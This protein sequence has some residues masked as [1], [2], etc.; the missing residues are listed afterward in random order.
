[1]RE[2]TAQET[3]YIELVHIAEVD[4]YVKDYVHGDSVR[5]YV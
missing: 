1:M 4:N 5:P 3:G 2:E